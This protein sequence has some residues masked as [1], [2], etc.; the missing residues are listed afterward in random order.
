MVFTSNKNPAL[1]REDFNEDSTLL[2]ALDRIFDEARVK[3]TQGKTQSSEDNP[4]SVSHWVSSFCWSEVVHTA[5]VKTK[6][7]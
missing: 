1:W 6:G 4:P 5:G 3:H 2:C 7:G